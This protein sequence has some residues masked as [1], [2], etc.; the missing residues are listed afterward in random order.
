MGLMLFAGP[1]R[2]ELSNNAGCECFADS[3]SLISSTHDTE[4]L[5]SAVPLM[6]DVVG[7]KTSSMAI[8][9]GSYRLRCILLPIK[10]NF[11]LK[12]QTVLNDNLPPP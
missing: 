7:G 1:K 4:T 9:L 6:M 10:T 3:L 5:V 8:S 12:R 2:P 11:L